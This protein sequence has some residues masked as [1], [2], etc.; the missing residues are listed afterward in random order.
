MKESWYDWYE[1]SRI[2]LNLDE[3]KDLWVEIYDPADLP[4][5]KQKKLA[6]LATLVR[7]EPTEEGLEKIE[8]VFAE[9][10]V[11]WSLKMPNGKP[12][13]PPKEQ[14]ESLYCLP[15]KYFLKIQSEIADLI[16][17]MVPGEARG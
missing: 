6:R 12:I 2:R 3:E 14:K 5:G 4:W 17:R 7:E 9:M 1:P 8:E 16:G 15:T 10:I 11:A 13:P